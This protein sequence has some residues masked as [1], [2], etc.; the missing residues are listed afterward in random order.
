[1]EGGI[2]CS[3]D[4]FGVYELPVERGVLALLVGSSNESVSLI[5][6]PFANTELVLSCA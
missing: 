5:L 6:E 3:D 1:M 4:D 2:R